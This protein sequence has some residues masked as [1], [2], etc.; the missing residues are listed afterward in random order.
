MWYNISKSNIV[1][2][3]KGDRAMAETTRNRNISI[4]VTEEELEI[5]KKNA[6]EMGLTISAY[7]VYTASNFDIIERLERIEE[8]I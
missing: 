7:L 4:R 6:K 5:I 8:K 2:I 3:R 1:F